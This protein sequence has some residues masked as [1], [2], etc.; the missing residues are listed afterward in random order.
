MEI[1]KQAPR[2]IFREEL[3]MSITMETPVERCLIFLDLV[4]VSGPVHVCWKYE[5][6]AKKK[7]PPFSSGHSKILKTRRRQ[8][9]PEQKLGKVLLAHDKAEL[10]LSGGRIEAE[11]QI[12]LMLL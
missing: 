5:P 11:G 4:S 10:W 1:A 7:V 3:N 2:A 8:K 9:Q 6:S 12:S